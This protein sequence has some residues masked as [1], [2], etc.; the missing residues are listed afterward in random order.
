VLEKAALT[1]IKRVEDFIG[2]KDAEYPED[3]ARKGYESAL[4]G[5]RVGV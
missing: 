1:A 4:E 5:A 2:E 3:P